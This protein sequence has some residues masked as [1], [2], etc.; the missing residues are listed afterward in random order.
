MELIGEKAS[1]IEKSSELAHAKVHELYEIANRTIS[2]LA[3]RV[4]ALEARGAEGQYVYPY[5]PKSLVPAKAM[6]PSKLAKLEEWK[7]WRVGLEDYAE[8]SLFGLKGA[9]RTVKA[10]NRYLFSKMASMKEEVWRMLK[11]CTESGSEVRRVIGGTLQDTDGSLGGGS[12]STSNH[13][14]RCAKD[15]S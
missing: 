13:A 2:S 14:W 3:G 12:M 1:E 7:R 11:T 6:V 9:L 15:K 4:D 5:N 8:A 10:E